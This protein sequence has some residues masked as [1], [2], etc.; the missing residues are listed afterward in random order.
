MQAGKQKAVD[1]AH[2]TAHRDARQQHQRAARYP[3]LVHRAHHAGAEH[4]VR[5]DRQIDAGGDQA[6][7][8]TGRQKRVEG[9]LL[10]YAHD[11]VVAVKILIGKRQDHAHDDQCRNG[12]QLN[13]A[14]ALFLSHPD[15]L[16]TLLS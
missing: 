13:I 15:S 3:R 16:P 2:Q 9:G 8:H 7:Q 10:Q 14:P 1:A 11:V 12:T 6:H 5:A 4:G